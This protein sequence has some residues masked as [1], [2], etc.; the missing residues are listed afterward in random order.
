MKQRDLSKEE[1]SSLLSS[2]RYGRL[3]LAKEDRP[4]IVPMSY[5]YADGR[6]YL[7][8]QGG[9]MKLE[10]AAANPRVCFQI[11]LLDKGRWSSVI[12][13]GPARLSDG[14]EAKQRMFDAFT[15]RGLGG[16]GGKKFSREELERMPMT[17]WE[18]EIEEL[19][20]REGVW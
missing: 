12:A 8:S 7:H 5:V 2:A 3:G 1:C 11:D 9:G 16:H 10:Y 19:T 15:A 14:I 6:I 13:F 4:Y 17:V 20:G 18:I